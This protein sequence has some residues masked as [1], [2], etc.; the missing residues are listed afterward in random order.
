MLINKKHNSFID[1]VHGIQWE[2]LQ[3]IWI[4]ATSWPRALLHKTVPHLHDLNPQEK[5]VLVII[6][7]N[8]CPLCPPQVHDSS[9]KARHWSARILQNWIHSSETL[10]TRRFALKQQYLTSRLPA[11]PVCKQEV[12]RSEEDRGQTPSP[13]P[14]EI[15]VQ[16]TLWATV[17]GGGW[18][19]QNRS[20]L[21]LN[22]HSILHSLICSRPHCHLRVTTVGSD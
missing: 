11:D 2:D 20:A 10:Q 19:A 6:Y 9:H 22:P 16:A 5:P 13:S 15:R 18:G 17:E 8:S 4:T 3:P 12:P 21:L 1:Y 7:I 14:R